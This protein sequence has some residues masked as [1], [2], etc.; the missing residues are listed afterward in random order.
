[1]AATPTLTIEAAKPA[2]LAGFYLALGFTEVAR[3]N[4]RVELDLGGLRLSILGGSAMSPAQQADPVVRG[5]Q[6]TVQV[7]DLASVRQALVAAGGVV[8]T[9]YRSAWS[10]VVV[11]DPIGN[12]VR[13]LAPAATATSAP[14][15]DTHAPTAPTAPPSIPSP[16]ADDT[17]PSAGVAAEQTPAP[18]P[19][20]ASADDDLQ[21]PQSPLPATY[22]N[23]HGVPTFDAVAERIQKQS[24]TADGNQVLDAESQRGREESDTMDKLK[25]AG[26]DRLD[27]LRKSMGI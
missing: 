23:E 24:A 16:D 12:P 5:L 26:K 20:I 2:E 14:S 9:E 11:L 17:A 6:L 27:Q 4:E 10:G 3:E 21:L 19:D 1:M 25:K 15:V 7:T 18:V 13:I 8:T 22:Y